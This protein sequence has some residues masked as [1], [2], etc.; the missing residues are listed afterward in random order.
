MYRS[1]EN[2][3][4]RRPAKNAQVSATT[5]RKAQA[6]I[7]HNSSE[8]LPNKLRLGKIKIDK[9]YRQIKNQQNSAFLVRNENES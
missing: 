3:S 5:H 7:N 1:M 8:E 2:I 6:I 4:L 9:A